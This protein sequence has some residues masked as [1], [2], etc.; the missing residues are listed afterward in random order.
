MFLDLTEIA[1]TDRHMAILR[2]LAQKRRKGGVPFLGRVG[3]AV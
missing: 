3:M 1:M 2:T